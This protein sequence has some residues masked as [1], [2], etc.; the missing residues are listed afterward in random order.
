LGASAGLNLMWDRY[1]YRYGER[2]VG[3][4]D[5]PVTIAAEWR[6]PWFEIA[7]FPRVVERRGC[8]QSPVDL[9]APEAA[10]RL[11]SYVWPDQTAR[12][13]RL[14]AAIALARREKPALDKADAG[15]WLERQLA[16]PVA[17]AATVV[18]HSIVWQYFSKETAARVRAALN[19]AGSRATSGAPLAWLSYEQHAPD[20][21]PEVR[22]TMWPGGERQTI[23]RAHAHGAWVEWRGA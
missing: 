16:E 4:A 8:D 19:D 12:L 7:E 18:A 20:Q 11:L 13:T 14:E 2:L 6:G 17:G 9:D 10:E 3:R 22:L 21:S 15:A 5:A 23:A 1:A